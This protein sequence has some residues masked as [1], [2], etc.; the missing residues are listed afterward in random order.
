MQSSAAWS[1]WPQRKRRSGF[2]NVFASLLASLIASLLACLLACVLACSPA[3]LLAWLLAYVLASF[4]ACLLLV[5]LVLTCT[6]ASLLP[7]SLG[8]M[9][10]C[11]RFC[12]LAYCFAGVLHKGWYR[13]PGGPTHHQIIAFSINPGRS[14]RW[15]S[16][17]GYNNRRE[18]P[19]PVVNAPD[20]SK[21]RLFR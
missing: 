10:A 3:G 12:L 9:I 19:T 8:W 6:Q 5:C 1:L 18:C 17:C 21:K 14:L 2:T 16:F 7:W 13:K 20:L 15:A 11:L 4:L